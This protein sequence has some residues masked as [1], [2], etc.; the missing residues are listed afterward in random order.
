VPRLLES[1]GPEPTGEIEGGSAHCR[2]Y[3]DN[4]DDCAAA[5]VS[6][7]TPAHG[8]ADSWTAKQAMLQETLITRT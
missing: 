1:D 7:P 5:I 3:A 2:T 4:G 8:Q 6:D